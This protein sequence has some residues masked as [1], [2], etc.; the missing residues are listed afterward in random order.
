MKKLLKI[1]LVVFLLLNVV[2]LNAQESKEIVIERCLEQWVSNANEE[3]DYTD[4]IQDLE[5]LY[6]Q[7]IPVNTA[8]ASDFERLPMLSESA[9]ANLLKYRER[10]GQIY[11]IYELQAVKGFS[12]ELLSDL[13]YFLSFDETSKQKI[14]LK[15]AMR[16]GQHSL[17]LRGRRY[18]I[19][20]KSS[21]AWWQRKTLERSFLRG[22]KSVVSTTILAMYNC[23]I[24]EFLKR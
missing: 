8:M 1:V 2:F 21:W 24:W 15:N 10:V 6:E 11:S 5:E 20:I 23:V 7:P 14:Q 3:Q 22:R 16:Y 4:W 13:Q 19:R 12:P 18:I 17:L 9:I